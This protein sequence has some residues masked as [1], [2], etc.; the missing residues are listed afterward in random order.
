MSSPPRE[1]KPSECKRN[2]TAHFG[3]QPITGRRNTT[4]YFEQCAAD[5]GEIHQH[6]TGVHPRDAVERVA[7]EAA[8]PANL[9]DL[10]LWSHCCE[11]AAVKGL[12][13]TPDVIHGPQ[14]EDICVHI[15]QRVHVLQDDL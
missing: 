2:I 3:F 10:V 8:V 9:G 14:E 15:E 5:P 6:D 11:L 13:E 12:Q 7:C 1:K 4:T